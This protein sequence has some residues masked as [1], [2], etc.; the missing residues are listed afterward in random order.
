MENKDSRPKRVESHGLI[1]YETGEIEDVQTISDTNYNITRLNMKVWIEG[2]DYVIRNICNSKTDIKLLQ[3]IRN[4]ADMQNQMMLSHTELSKDFNVS[5][6]KITTFIKKAID[7]GF[8]H[9]KARG[10]YMMNPFIVISN[11]AWKIGGSKLASKLQSDWRFQV[12]NPPRTNELEEAKSLIWST[13]NE[14]TK[15]FERTHN[16]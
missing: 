9:R 4:K 11:K 7:I 1:N 16:E 8:I 6:Q 12:G 14:E 3:E 10:L 15:S 13:Y 2:Y 5:I